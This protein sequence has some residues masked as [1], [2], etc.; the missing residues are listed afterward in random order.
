ME[1]AFI[2]ENYEKIDYV[3]RARKKGDGPVIGDFNSM[4]EAQHAI[5]MVV[6][7]GKPKRMKWLMDTGRGHNLM[8]RRWRISYRSQSA[9]CGLRKIIGTDLHPMVNSASRNLSSSH[10]SILPLHLIPL[11]SS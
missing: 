4:T 9:I 7:S 11:S 3:D 10:A 6:K 2:G 5:A 8:G 1:I